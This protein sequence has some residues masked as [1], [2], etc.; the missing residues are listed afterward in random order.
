MQP[1]T[2]RPWESERSTVKRDSRVALV[3]RGRHDRPGPVPYDV[4]LLAG[5]PRCLTLHLPP[6][7]SA[8]SVIEVDGEQ[9]A[10]ADVRRVDGSTTQLI[11]I[12]NV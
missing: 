7:I 8:E 1:L 12:H 10:V 4:V 3:E 2:R 5:S 11:C 9:W 6:D